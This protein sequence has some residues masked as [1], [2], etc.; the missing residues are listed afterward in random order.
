MEK[1]GEE[2]VL[3]V[4]EG[5]GLANE[6]EIVEGLQFDRGYLSPYFITDQ[7][8][9][10]AEL[11]NPS[12]LLYDKKVS[13]IRDLLPLLEALAKTGDTTQAMIAPIPEEKKAGPEYPPV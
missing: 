5:S 2:G 3:T 4:E 9:Q 8:E 6:M 7:E 1:V 13:S 10:R 11:E 12:I